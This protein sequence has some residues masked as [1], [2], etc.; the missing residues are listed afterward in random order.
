MLLDTNAHEVCMCMLKCLKWRLKRW[1]SL[2]P[3]HSALWSHTGQQRVQTCPVR[4]HWKGPQSH[5][6]LLPVPATDS[7]YLAQ[8]RPFFPPSP[9]PCSNTHSS[10]TRLSTWCGL[11][12][13][14]YI[15]TVSSTCAVH[16]LDA[17]EKHSVT[18]SSV[19]RDVFEWF[20]NN[21]FPLSPVFKPQ[22]VRHVQR[23]YWRPLCLF[24]N[25]LTQ[26]IVQP[27]VYKS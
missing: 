3:L 16:S 18:V 19:S 11:H 24:I 14:L 17:S 21:A 1:D 20:S 8:Q 7:N 10:R 5:L 23:T 26:F 9:C 27:C 22:Q 2:N 4:Y 13:Y 12:L 25:G 6:L 15:C